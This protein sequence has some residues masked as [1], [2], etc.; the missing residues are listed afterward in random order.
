MADKAIMQTGDELDETNLK[1]WLGRANLADYVETGLGFTPDF[2]NVV[3]DIGDGKAV[4]LDS[5]TGKG[6][7]ITVLPD[8]RTGL[9]LTDNATNHVFLTVDPSVDDGVSYHIDT[10]NTAPAN[11]SLKVGT[12]DTSN[13]TSTELNRDPDHTLENLDVGEALDLV[14]ETQLRFGSDD[15]RLQ[16]NSSTDKLEIVDG[17]GTIY[18]DFDSTNGR[19][20]AKEP[21]YANNGVTLFG[22]LNARN[23]AMTIDMGS[24][25]DDVWLGTSSLYDTA[26]GII[27]QAQTNPTSGDAIFRVLSSGGSERLRVEHAGTTSTTNHLQ[28]GGTVDGNKLSVNGGETIAQMVA[29]SGQVQLSSGSAIV[30]TN[31]SAVDATFNLALGVDDPGADCKVTGRLFWDDSAGTYKVEMMEDGTSVG[32]PTINYDVIRVR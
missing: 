19:V 7:D 12:V 24:T 2:T 30:S 3:L 6:Q 9:A 27:A 25:S 4:I 17:A 1:E 29:A 28:A 16:Y 22:T 23:E 14:G 31:V 8:A 13:N 20:T 18:F 21:L 5:S 11:P 26:D 32:N 15:Y 10:D